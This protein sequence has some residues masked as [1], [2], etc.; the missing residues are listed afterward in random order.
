MRRQD[1]KLRDEDRISKLLS[2]ATIGRLGTVGPDGPM[3]KPVN[4]VYQNGSF[5]FHGAL[6][7]EKM[8]HIRADPRVVFQVERIQ[9]YIKSAGK[10]CDS[11]QAYECVI[12]R[13][14]AEVVDDPAEKTAA[15]N[16][17][18]EKHQPE[19]GWTPVTEAMAETVAVVSV[20]VER[21]TA[22]TSPK[23]IL[24]AEKED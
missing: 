16:A 21:M 2:E 4:Y 17:L 9:R 1:K 11:S 10:P 8:D 3:I 13:G 12:A 20:R 23:P 22:K 7:G 5:Y 15:L 19:G 14:R 24:R 18:M 6:E